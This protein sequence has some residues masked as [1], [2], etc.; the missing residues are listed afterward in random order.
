MRRLPERP[1]LGGGDSGAGTSAP[2][3][4]CRQR[5]PHHTVGRTCAGEAAL[6]APPGP[7]RTRGR[8]RGHGPKLASPQAVGAPTAARPRLMVTWPGGPPETVRSSPA[9][10]PGPA[11][12]RPSWTSVGA[13]SLRGQASIAIRMACRLSGAWA[14]HRSWRVIP[15]AGRSLPPRPRRPRL[16][17]A[18][19]PHGRWPTNRATIHARL[20]RTVYERWP[21]RSAAPAPLTSIE[22]GSRADSGDQPRVFLGRLAL[23]LHRRPTTKCTSL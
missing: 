17:A 2:A 18:G 9:P 6:D 1:G 16:P 11:S 4:L 8:P 19:I 13:P 14:R 7:R 3:R 20:V 15:S 22:S 10:S 23:R 5:R 21:T 12:G